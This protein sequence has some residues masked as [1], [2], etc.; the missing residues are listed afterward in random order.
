MAGGYKMIQF[1]VIEV[2]LT[3]YGVVMVLLGILSLLSGVGLRAS[4]EI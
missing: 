3:T 2:A 1:G 4:T